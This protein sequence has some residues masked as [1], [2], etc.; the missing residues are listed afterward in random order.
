MEYHTRI[1]KVYIIRLCSIYSNA[2]NLIE[3][4]TWELNKFG[5]LWRNMGRQLH[6]F[7]DNVGKR[8]GAPHMNKE[9]VFKRHLI[10][11]RVSPQ[12]RRLNVYMHTLFATSLANIWCPSYTVIR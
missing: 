10:L 9:G 5:L 12:H 6:L 2:L 4:F 3:A 11:A 7:I 1:L 8:N